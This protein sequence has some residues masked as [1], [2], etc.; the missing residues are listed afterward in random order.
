VIIT[1]KDFIMSF[2]QTNNDDVVEKISNHDIAPHHSIHGRDDNSSHI[3]HSSFVAA[4]KPAY[5]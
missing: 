2:L 5:C 1:D 4:Q 3:S